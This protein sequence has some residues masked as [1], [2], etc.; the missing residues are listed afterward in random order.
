M[1]LPLKKTIN[2]E[3]MNEWIMTQYHGNAFTIYINVDKDTL[4]FEYTVKQFHIWDKLIKLKNKPVYL[5]KSN[6]III[7]VYSMSAE[8]QL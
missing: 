7:V 2:D 8:N 5:Y 6:Q 4:S 3:W 1:G